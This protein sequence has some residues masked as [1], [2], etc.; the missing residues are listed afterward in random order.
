VRIL[1]IPFSDPMV[2]A[3]RAGRKTMTRR[4][5]DPQPFPDGYHQ[6]QVFMTP[7]PQNDGSLLCRFSAEAVGGG[8]VIED[9]IGA[10]YAVG[11]H[12]W[13]RETYFQLGHWEPVSGVKTKGGKQKWAFIPDDRSIL[14]APPVN[15]EVRLGRHHIDPW[16]I[17]WHKRLGRFMPK[18]ASR[19]TLVVEGVKVE[20]LMDIPEAD[21]RAEGIIVQ[22]VITDTKCYGGPPIEETADRYWNGT[23]PEDFE[24]HECAVDAF[25]DLW[26]HINGAG[27]WAE[28]PWVVAYSFRL[29][30]GNV[31]EIAK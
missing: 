15:G 16:K 2:L 1:P 19:M 11:D 30:E 27:S 9:T 28:N 4:I 3:L 29:V 10:R 18:V 12:L 21:T 24:G 25:A 31:E 5:L 6:G 13:V 7:L 22:N 8:A 26:G 17:A 14:F 23:E 20:R